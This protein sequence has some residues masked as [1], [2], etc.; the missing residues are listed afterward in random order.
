MKIPA[1]LFAFGVAFLASGSVTAGV[2]EARDNAFSIESTVSSSAPPNVV[3]R[4]LG[5]VAGWWDPEHSWSGSA[6]NLSL[7]L[8]AGGCFCEKLA[9][10][11]SVEH[12]RVI[13]AQPGVMVRLNAPLG[14]L[15][16]MPVTAVLTYKLAPEGSG[17]AITMTFRVSGAMTMGSA[18]LA[19][20]VDQVMNVQLGRLKAYSDTLAARK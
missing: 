2:V 15:Q 8:Q 16:G 14:P 4:A 20:I 5:N 12:G 3:Y 13:Y 7:H 19:P 1:G 6:K 18:K 10:G 17:T 11:G 9:D